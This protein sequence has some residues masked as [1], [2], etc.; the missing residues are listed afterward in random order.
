MR[1]SLL[2]VLMTIGALALVETAG[3][4]ELKK[5]ELCG[6]VGCT[7]ITDRSTLREIPT[8]G[9]TLTEPPALASFYTMRLTVDAGR[10]ESGWQVY[11]V[12]SADAIAARDEAG[13]IRWFPI[14]GE[15]VGLME[16]LVRGL[17]PF[18]APTISSVTVG[19][20]VVSGDP[21]TY[22]RLYEVE[23]A[24]SSSESPADWVPID[25][26][27]DTR[28]PWT[29]GPRELM[30]SPST[31]LLERGVEVIRLPHALAADVEAGRT[32][33]SDGRSG[34]WWLL[35]LSAAV[36]I[37]LAFVGLR[38]IARRRHATTGAVPQA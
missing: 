16:R 38:A 23:G 30:Y 11:Y 22:L 12:P 15:A 37:P 3:A 17:E 19:G 10:D 24:T 7:A 8:G 36:L 13:R 33:T 26:V 5:V 21:S 2:V 28:S 32:F 29:D 35:A 6:P 14:F 25:F 18:P 1:R 27:S 34:L 4:K 9:E 31:D 20:E